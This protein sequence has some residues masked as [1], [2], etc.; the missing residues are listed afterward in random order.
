MKFAK[1]Y[2]KNVDIRYYTVL[3]ESGE[4]KEDFIITYNGNEFKLYIK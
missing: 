4:L 3:K 2:L 1:K